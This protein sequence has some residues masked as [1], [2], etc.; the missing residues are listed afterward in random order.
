[1]SESDVLYHY[2]PNT[3]LSYI[4]SQLLSLED[5]CQFDIALCNKIKRLEYLKCIKSNFSIFQGDKIRNSSHHEISWMQNRSINIRHLKCNRICDCI[6]VQIADI[7]SSL[8]WLSINADMTDGIERCFFTKKGIVRIADS[9][10]NLQVYHFVATLAMI[11][12]SR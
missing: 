5:I 7:G 12:Y 2:V 1:M 6:A 3:I 8:H 9:C 10:P 4:F 11:M